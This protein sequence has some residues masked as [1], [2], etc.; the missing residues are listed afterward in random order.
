MKYR[1][2][3]QSTLCDIYTQKS[4]EI[5]SIRLE[6]LKIMNT[7]DSAISCLTKHDPFYLMDDRLNLTGNV[8]GEMI[9]NFYFK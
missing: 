9:M 3:Y 7:K 5:I 1:G 8:R 4:D 2:V 6:E